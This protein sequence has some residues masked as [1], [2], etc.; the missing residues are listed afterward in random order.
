MTNSIEKD[1]DIKNYTTFKIGGK[2]REV[3]FPQSVEEIVEIIKQNRNIPVLGNLSNTLISTHGYNNK[4]ILT[5]KMNKIVINGTRVV[6]DCGVKGPKLALEVCK[7]GLSGLEFMIGFPGSVGGEVCMNASANSQA[8]S[9]KLVSVL[10]YSKKHGLITYSKEKMG[11]DYRTSRCQKEPDLIVLRAE[12]ELDNKD[13]AQIQAQMDEN[14]QF[15]RK[16]QPSLVLPNCG[17][18]F[19]NPIGNPAGR[20]LESVG[21]KELVFGGA[22]VWRN[23]SNFIVNI[24]NATSYDVLSLMCEMQDRVKFKYNIKLEP[25]I[26]FLCGNNKE[27]NKLWQKLNKK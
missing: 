15:R 11:F 27:E 13:T 22:R 21:A 12:F 2:I 6:A 10:C 5:S 3:Y 1:F 24:N 25:E 8:I 17:S 23:H 16:H 9:D 14:L 4:I 18:I 20:L 19:K 26:K 7:N